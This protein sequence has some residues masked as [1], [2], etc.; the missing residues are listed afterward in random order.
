M[1]MERGHLEDLGIDDRI[2]GVTE[3]GWEVADWIHVA[4]DRHQWR[5]A[6][7]TAMKGG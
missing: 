1:V 5:A 6:I 7:N 4:Q 3:I 2:M